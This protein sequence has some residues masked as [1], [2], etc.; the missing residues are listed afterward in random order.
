MLP[1][2]RAAEF[3]SSPH[4][5]IAPGSQKIRIVILKMADNRQ[6]DEF[7]ILAQ[8]S[9]GNSDDAPSSDRAAAE[10]RSEPAGSRSMSSKQ[11]SAMVS[12]K[13]E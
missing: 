6:S 9:E 2:L 3:S 1:P 4:S 8:L 7:S 12:F 10:K 5:A 11:L 13:Q